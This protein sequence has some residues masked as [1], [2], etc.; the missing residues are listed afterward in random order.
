MHRIPAMAEKVTGPKSYFPSIE[1]KYAK[2][3]DYWMQ[4]LATVPDLTHMQQVQWLKTEHGWVTVT[5]TRSSPSIGAST[6]SV[7]RVASGSLHR[8][9]EPGEV[10]V[11][12][13]SA[14][15]SRLRNPRRDQIGIQTRY[16]TF[17]RSGY[18]RPQGGSRKRSCS[19]R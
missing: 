7:R 19:D 1:K 9:E 10:A 6:P 12:R 15:R 18:R 13:S 14:I 5:R 17:L 8:T 11:D 4:Q 3:I 2:P 16:V